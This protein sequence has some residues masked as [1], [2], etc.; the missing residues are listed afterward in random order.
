L[1]GIFNG[2]PFWVNLRFVHLPTCYRLTLTKSFL[3]ILPLRIVKD[4]DF[5]VGEFLVFPIYY[6]QDPHGLQCF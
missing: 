3:S 5:L 2:N 6:T 4:M 1:V